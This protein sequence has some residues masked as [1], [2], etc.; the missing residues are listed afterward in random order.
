V[1]ADPRHFARA[2][3]V[4]ATT[5]PLT[6][7]GVGPAAKADAG[8]VYDIPAGIAADCSVDV[9]GPLVQFIAA[10]PDGSANQPNVV[11][12]ARNAC[13]HVD[14]PFVVRQ[15]RNLVIEGNDATIR[16]F[17]EHLLT[18]QFP[19][20][21][22]HVE[23]DD[24]ANV[25]LE[26]LHV[27]GLNTQ[28]DHPSAYDPNG[29]GS[30]YG[31]TNA[32]ESAYHFE[33]LDGL[34]VTNVTSDATFGDGI[35]LGSEHAPS[36]A[37]NV[38]LSNISIDRNGRQGVAVG[39]ADHVLMDGIH[40]WHSNATGFDLEPNGDTSYTTNVEIRNSY[41]NSRTVAFAATGV[42]DTSNIDIHDNTVRWSALSWPWV[43][44]GDNRASTGRRHDWRV[45]HNQVLTGLDSP[46]LAFSNTDNVEVGDNV[47]PVNSSSN[48][49]VAKFPGVTLSGV[50]GTVTVTNNDFSGAGWVY[51]ADSNTGRVRACDNRIAEDGDFDRPRNCSSLPL[52]V[53]R[54]P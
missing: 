7:L 43:T 11:R 49:E 25:T 32:F 37:A 26:N 3:V 22:A 44:E 5:A 48:P 9:T 12:F 20:G 50:G 1:K 39:A 4:L 14:L 42:Q 18:T 46:A 16:R 35:T 21:Y 15:H 51:A 29:F 36:L 34:T 31:T 19:A 41:V 47:S 28:S 8:T 13:Y 23:I 38:R 53:T 6:L 45:V 17:R 27:V 52:G 24:V 54:S 10:V 30:A 40:I 2:L 33:S